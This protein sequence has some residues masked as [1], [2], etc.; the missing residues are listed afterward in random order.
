MTNKVEIDGH[1]V[2]ADKVDRFYHGSDGRRL[3]DEEWDVSRDRVAE[4]VDDLKSLGFDFV[5]DELPED[6]EFAQ[7]IEE[8][9]EDEEEL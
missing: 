7:G 1:L 4:T 9:V 2:D 8:G 6:H 5:G 3:T